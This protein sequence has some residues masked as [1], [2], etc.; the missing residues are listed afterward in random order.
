MAEETEAK[1]TALPT[2]GFESRISL[3][4]SSLMASTYTVS[5][6]EIKFG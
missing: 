3:K 2:T 6:L 4:F 1:K 5:R